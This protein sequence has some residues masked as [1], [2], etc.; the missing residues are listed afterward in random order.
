MR[1]AAAMVFIAVGLIAAGCSSSSKSASSSASPSSTSASSS[2]SAAGSSSSASSAAANGTVN[3]A[4]N[5]KFGQI[6]VGPNGKTL[7]MFAVETGTT[8]SCKGGCATVWPALTA[9]GTPQPG[10]SVDA[11]K[12]GTADGQVAGQITYNGHLLYFFSGDANPGDVNG[13]NIPNWFPLSPA[14][15]KVSM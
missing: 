6:L 2:T 5:P 7:Y 15:D 11:A 3:V 14:G 8:S 13:T 1:R 9:S 4:S 12:L 10:A